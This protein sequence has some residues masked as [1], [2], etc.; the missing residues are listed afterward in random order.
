MNTGAIGDAREDGNIMHGTTH[1]TMDLKAK[2]IIHIKVIN[3]N[4]NTDLERD[5]LQLNEVN[6]SLK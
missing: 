4:V 2:R 1:N 6:R 3:S 5:S